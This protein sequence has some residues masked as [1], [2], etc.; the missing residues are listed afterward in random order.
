MFV[1][2]NKEAD[3]KDKETLSS[4]FIRTIKS[5]IVATLQQE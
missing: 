1:F 4:F 3:T 5:N 2:A